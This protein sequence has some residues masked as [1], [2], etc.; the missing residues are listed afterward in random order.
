MAQQGSKETTP[1]E[2]DTIFAQLRLDVAAAKSP[3]ML[4]VYVD[5]AEILVRGLELRE[6]ARVRQEGYDA[7]RSL[8]KLSGG[9]SL[10][11]LKR[12]EESN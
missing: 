3:E 8:S 4:Q 11:T 9:G 2:L 6:F 10:V 1:H 5:R 12:G 7:G